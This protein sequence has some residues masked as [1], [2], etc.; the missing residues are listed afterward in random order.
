MGMVSKISSALVFKVF[1][2]AC[3]SA[4]GH[5][6]LVSVVCVL[7]S[8][9]VQIKVDQLFM[10]LK[11]DMITTIQLSAYKL[12]LLSSFPVLLTHLFSLVLIVG[13]EKRHC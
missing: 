3:Y 8:G 12:L 9:V 11:K 13:W 1:Y 7:L 5:Y 2:N 4:L 6:V 10:V